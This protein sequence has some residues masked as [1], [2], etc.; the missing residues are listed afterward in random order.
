VYRIFNTKKKEFALEVKIMTHGKRKLTLQ[1]SNADTPSGMTPTFYAKSE[2]VCDYPLKNGNFG[3]IYYVR[4]PQ[5]PERSKFEILADEKSFQFKIKSVPLKKQLSAFNYSS[6]TIQSFIP[7]AQ[8]FAERA[9]YTSAQKSVYM[10][11]DGQFRIDYVDEIIDK[12]SGKALTTPARISRD[13]GLIEI[14]RKRF[15]PY[16]VQGR[17]AILLHEFA[18]Y[19]LNT[20]MSDETE[21]DM[22][23]LLIYL[24][25]GYS[26]IEAMNVFLDVFYVAATDGN[27]KRY[28]SIKRMIV[29][30]DRVGFK[31]LGGGYYYQDEK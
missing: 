5:S 25:M 12:K 15:V 30:F 8:K 31:P 29:N 13:R 20:K 16:T 18:H 1:I 24:G 4:M 6:P 19:Y 26:K 27:R 9:S 21:A 22:N 10:S 11:D 17:M 14:S 23:A 2:I 3:G 28:N 7:F